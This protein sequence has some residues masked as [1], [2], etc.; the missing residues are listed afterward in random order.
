MPQAIVGRALCF[1]FA[2]TSLATTSS[3]TA[4]FLRILRVPLSSVGAK[5]NQEYLKV[6]IL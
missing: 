4:V 5:Y 6:Y 1:H 2:A 3:T